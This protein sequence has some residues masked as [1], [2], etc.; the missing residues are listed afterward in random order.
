MWLCN[1]LFTNKK[2]THT[3]SWLQPLA[4]L[5][6]NSGHVQII[7]ISFGKYNIPNREI[8]NNGII[9]WSIPSRKRF[10]NGM[11]PHKQTCLEIQD[12]ERQERPDL[13]HVWGTE[14]IWSW[15]ATNGYITS[16]FVIDIQGLLAPY[17]YYYY[18]GLSFRE[19][20]KCIHL[21]EIIMPWRTL[22]YKK[23][24]FYKR[25]KI[26]T[27][28]LKKCTHISV[29]S[30][31]V[32]NYI[33]QLTNSQCHTYSTKILL[34]D[35]FYT[36]KAWQF[37]QANDSPRI[38]SSCSAAVS[39]K[40]MHILIK[41]ISLLKNKYPNIQVRLAGTINIGN[42]LLDGYSIY[43]NN[44][45]KKYRLSNNITY[46]GSLNDLEIIHELQQANVCVIPSFIETYCLAF[47]ESMMIGVPTVV[48][49]AGAMPELVNDKIGALFY[50]PSDYY[51]CAAH[52]NTLITNKDLTKS[53]SINGREHRLIENNPQ[54]VLNT[55][56]A[57]YNSIIHC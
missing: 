10:H 41:A 48:A 37:K 35:N 17:T 24:I 51:T 28:C 53:L 39:Y 57:I 49:Y 13:V 55:Q 40:G 21:K 14:N 16:K 33:I 38:F 23:F 1:L 5:L 29:Q 27:A 36:A 43:L 47:A 15:V 31:W 11:V 50:N 18:G 22:F 9:Q 34:R 32:K 46:L 19:I 44:L 30:D 8:L 2:I 3:G 25:G 20:L 7:N 56:I 42:R 52:I 26:E 6:Q 45:I 54:T 12:I 4:E